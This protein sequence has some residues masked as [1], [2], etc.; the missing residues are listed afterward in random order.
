MLSAEEQTTLNSLSWHWEGAYLISV[1]DG[2]WLASPVSDPS[3]T[4]TRGT[5]GELREALRIDY[6]ERGPRRPAGGCS[7]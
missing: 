4:I 5:A 3:V 1:R 2:A 7:L 6:S